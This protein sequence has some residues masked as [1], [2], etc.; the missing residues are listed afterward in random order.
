MS[1]D[2]RRLL[3]ARPDRHRPQARLRAHRLRHHRERGPCEPRGGV[4]RVGERGRRHA[5]PGR[6][7]ARAPSLRALRGCALRAPVLRAVRAGAAAR[8]RCRH[9]RRD[10]R[11]LPHPP[12][13]HLRP[14]QPRRAG[15][16]RERAPHRHRRDRA[17]DGARPHRA[18]RNGPDQGPARGMVPPIGRSHG[19]R[20]RPPAH[21]S[22]AR[23]AR[24]RHHRI[25]G[26]DHSRAAPLAGQDDRRRLRGACALFSLSPLAGRGDS[27]TQR[28]SRHLRDRQEQLLQDRRGDAGRPRQDGLLA[29]PEVRRRLLLRRVRRQGLHGGAGTRPA[30]PPGVDAGRRARRGGGLRRRRARRRRLHPQR[31]LLRRQPSARRQCRPPRLLRRPPARLHLPARAL[32][33]R[34]FRHAGQ[35]RRRHRDLRRGPAPAAAAARLP[36]ARPTSTSR[37]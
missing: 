27:S 17:P 34:R 36:R 3:G 12:S 23:G 1:A 28:R 29:D 16:A 25:A 32:A 2:P 8:A 14:R 22:R 21:A 11:G 18:S 19:Q 37:R 35:L 31:S 4:R 24:P 5:R 9:P 13:R 6:H 10:R 26:I 20:L 33:R 15:A 7:R 30:D